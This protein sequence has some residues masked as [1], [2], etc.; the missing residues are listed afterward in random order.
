MIDVNM[1][2]AWVT[3]RFLRVGM[4]PLGAADPAVI[5]SYRLLG[6]LG[7]GG[8][9]RVYLGQSPTGRRLAIKVIRSEL[10]ED[11]VFRRRFARE[12]AAVRKV[13]PL[14]TAAVVDADPTAESPWLATTYIE[15][16]SLQQ[17][18]AQSG[19]LSARAV[20]TLG[21]GLAEALASIHGAGLVHRDLKPGNVLLDDAGPHIIDFGIVLSK[22]TTRLTTSL[23]GTP[24]YM[25]PERINGG[26]ADPAGDIF[27]LGA[28]LVFAAT[29]KSLVHDGTMYEQMMQISKGRFDLSGVPQE[30]R[31]LIV[32]CI[33]HQAK[34]RPRAEELARI[35]VG[36]G[37]SAPTRGW[38]TVDPADERDTQPTVDM[39]PKAKTRHRR[40]TWSRRQVL[41]T[42]GLASAVVIGGA[43]A[44]LSRSGGPLW[45]ADSGR[46]QPTAPV[47][48]GTLLWQAR[49]GAPVPQANPNMAVTSTTA[50]R[51]LVDRGQRLISATGG[52][53]NAVDPQGRRVWTMPLQTIRLDL[54][55][56]GTQVVATDLKQ[57]WLLDA[58]TGELNLVM[59]LVEVESADAHADDPDD[60]AV[61]IYGVAT[62]GEVAFVGL[63]TATIAVNR[64]GTPQWREPRPPQVGKIRPPAGNPVAAN[65]THLVTQDITGTTAQV[66]LID[67][68]TG[69]RH[70]TTRYSLPGAQQVPTVPAPGS[71]PPGGGPLGGLQDTAWRRTEV[72]LT[73]TYIAIRD[74]QQIR[75]LR[76]GDGGQVWYFANLTPVAGIEVLGDQV[77]VAADRLTGYALQTGEV[78]WQSAVRGARICAAPDGRTLLAADST[79]IY[80]L[81]SQG[82]SRWQ[83]RLPTQLTGGVPDRLTADA[84]TAY[85]TLSPRPEVSGNLPADV[86]AVAL[87]AQT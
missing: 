24:S 33:G 9:G 6:V 57:M 13:S 11:P 66:S 37:I 15:G 17:Y 47:T 27:A 72:K 69:G 10:A 42:G 26:E 52:T 31:P 41:V 54:R 80:A 87:D 40:E 55:L 84:H 32:R 58:R 19:P 71:S 62:A 7:G 75:V 61:E 65:A 39:K 34:D 46:R 12:V 68:A 21:A 56:W 16:P 20:L 30:L 2:D 63:G 77:V 14:F 50:T 79:A 76:V 45:G 74:V 59:N 85:L 48:P 83:A 4:K 64:I 70:W 3:G 38:Y 78:V 43:V 73:D 49:S 60:L 23:V 67:P 81:D 82:F 5:A 1:Y 36:S 8:M 18:V 28:T 44:A 22:D 25:A 53:I 51:V 29:G 86:V 35:L